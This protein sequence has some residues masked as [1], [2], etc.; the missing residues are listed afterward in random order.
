MSRLSGRS[1]WLGAVGIV[2]VLVSAFAVQ[3]A[4]ADDS[5]EVARLESL[6]TAQQ[7]RIEALQA[8]IEPVAASAQ[9]A[10][11]AD[12]MRQQIR[13]IL[14]EQE[15]RESLMPS[16][17][18]A[19]YD[20]GFF[21]RS[22]DDKFKLKINGRMQFRWTHYGTQA[23]N[24][25]TAPRFERNDYTGFDAKRVRLM[26]SGHAYTPDLT[27]LIKLHA[28]APGAYDVRIMYAFLN[29]RFIDEFQVKAGVFEMVGTR[30]GFQSSANMQFVEYPVTEAVFGSSTGTGVR[31]WGQLFDKRLE[32]FIDVVN[33]LNGTGNRTITTDPAEL[34]GNPALA[35]RAVWHV[36][37]EDPTRDFVTWGDL[38]HKT[39]PCLDL[40]FSY[41][42]NEDE[43]DLATTRI[44]FV[45]HTQTGGAFGLTNTNGMQVNHFG[46]DAAF[47]YQGFSLSGEYMLRLLDVRRAG[48]TPFTPLWLLTGDDSTT[49]MHGGYVQT[50]YFLPIPGHEKKLEAVA[51]VGGISTNAG[52]GGSEGTWVYAAGLNYYFEGNKVKLQTDVTKVDEVPTSAGGWLANVN[53]GALIWR[54]QLQVA[55]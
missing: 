16:M 44:P 38:D 55:F 26:F 15:F 52:P 2:A 37:G 31:F 1:S 11:R 25:Y 39:T 18:Q 46:V 6:L 54:V 3:G 33:S 22:S 36:M 28:D 24:R 21:I 8:Q 17:L 20:G 5:N 30:A 41:I 48:R 19:G 27:Y 43:G 35:F 12:A 10:G 53:D 29:Y 14:G 23:R 45:R 40:G 9:D 51:R 49:A 4:F 42:F 50:G 34:D 32:Y 7:Q 47:K 13:D